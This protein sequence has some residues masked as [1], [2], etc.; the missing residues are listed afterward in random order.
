M[1]FS[2]SG[3]ITW[4]IVFLGNP[5]EKYDGTRHNVGFQVGDAVAKHCGV[6]IRRL[7]SRA[8]TARATLGGQPVLL[9]KPQTY[10]NLSGEAAR[11][12]ADYYKIPSDHVLVVLDDTALAPGRLRLRPGGSA[13]G[14]NGL[15]SLIGRLGTDKFPRLRV[16]V[17][18]PPHRTTP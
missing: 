11:P 13:G 7:K 8:L 9:V 17:G 12:L 15:K 6:H 3:P 2:R 10:M 4:M 16:G 14:H 5:G 1:L 18:A